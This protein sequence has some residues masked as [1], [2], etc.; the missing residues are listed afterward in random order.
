LESN[1]IDTRLLKCQASFFL[2][3]CNKHRK[4]NRD[5]YKLVLVPSICYVLLYD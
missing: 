1:T 2:S 3:H 5:V 4:S